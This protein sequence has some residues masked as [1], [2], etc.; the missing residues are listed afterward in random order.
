MHEG[1]RPRV[2]KLEAKV[3]QLEGEISGMKITELKSKVLLLEKIIE[4]LVK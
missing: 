2:E 3:A 4:E 1:D